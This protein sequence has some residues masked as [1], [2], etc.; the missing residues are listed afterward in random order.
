[1]IDS[2]LMEFQPSN[3]WETCQAQAH[4]QERQCN[5]VILVHS[6][7]LERGHHTFAR[8]APL[9]VELD[10]CIVYRHQPQRH[11]STVINF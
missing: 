1:V 8:T 6:Q 7:A 4:R 11:R 9:R 2:D 3:V 5:F 10:N